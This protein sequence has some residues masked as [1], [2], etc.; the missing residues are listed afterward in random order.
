M[1]NND[2][3]DVDNIV[4]NNHTDHT[5]DNGEWKQLGSSEQLWMVNN[6]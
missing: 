6:R 4:A 3:N 2:Y 5:G 1:F